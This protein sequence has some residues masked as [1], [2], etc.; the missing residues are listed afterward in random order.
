MK[1][2]FSKRMT[3]KQFQ[4]LKI[5]SDRLTVVAP[6][7]KQYIHDMSNCIAITDWQENLLWGM[8][9]DG[10]VTEAK[11]PYSTEHRLTWDSD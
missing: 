5:A 4:A 9:E 7:I 11:D 10:T 3:H 8:M 1:E 6:S 2:R